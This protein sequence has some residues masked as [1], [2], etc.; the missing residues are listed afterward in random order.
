MR[1]KLIP[2]Q[3]KS[4][5]YKILTPKIM[6]IPAHF[7]IKKISPK[8]DYSLHTEYSYKESKYEDKI[9]KDLYILKD[10]NYKG[11]PLLWFNKQWG[12]QFFY[13]IK[14]LTNEQKIPKIIEIHP[15]FKD[16]CESFDVFLERYTKFENLIYKHFPDTII[17]IE[18]RY[19]STYKLSKFLLSSIDDIE[20]FI[21]KLKTKDL[22]LKI[23]LD[24]PTLIKVEGGPNKN[25][26]NKIINFM[27][28]N[29]HNNSLILSLHFWG[30]KNNKVHTGDLDSLFNNDKKLKRDFLYSIS[31]ILNDNIPRYFLPEVNFSSQEDFESLIQDI[32]EYFE[33]V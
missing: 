31:N 1:A 23:A 21:E 20:I 9:F 3:Y 2:I 30:R 13:F 25:T 22:N 6:E 26:I 17:L 14:N 24:I 18:N 16:Y 11:V 27:S 7:N 5:Q 15:P 29:K 4:F 12:E 32:L 19:G 10:S 28:E 33:F 8:I